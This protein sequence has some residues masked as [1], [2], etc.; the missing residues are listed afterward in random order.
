MNSDDIAEVRRL[1]DEGDPV[2]M[3]SLGSLLED[4]AKLD[5]AQAWWHKAADLGNSVA[6][7]NLGAFF[8]RKDDLERAQYWWCRAADAG[9]TQ[10]LTEV[11]S[12]FWRRGNL[13]EAE[14][15]FRQ[16]IDRGEAVAQYLGGLLYQKGDRFEAEAWFRRAAESGDLLSMYNLG[17]LLRENGDHESAEAWLRKAAVEGSA[18]AAGSL[19]HLLEQRGEGED[20]DVWYRK[21]AEANDAYAMAHLGRRLQER[22]QDDEAEVWLRKATAQGNLDATGRLGY[23][24]QR[25]DKRDEA[26]FWLRKAAEGGNTYAV[27]NLVR[28]LH[29]SGRTQESASWLAKVDVSGDTDAMLQL[30]FLYQH[31]G[32][33]ELAETWFWRAADAKNAN[34]AE[35]LTALRRKLTHTDQK[36]DLITFDTFGWLLTENGDGYRVWR[37]AQGV[38]REQFLDFAPDLPSLDAER[39]REVTLEMQELVASPTFSLQEDIP[40]QSHKYFRTSEFPQQTALLDVESFEV[41]PAKCVVMENRHRSHERVHYSTGMMILFAACFWVIAVDVEEEKAT[42]GERESSVARYLL[43]S[44]AAEDSP[45]TFNPYDRRWDGLVP[46]EH[47]PLTRMRLLTARLRTSIRLGAGTSQLEPFAPEDD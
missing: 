25:Q 12:A 23:L 17:T 43:E 39:I 29:E 9:D 7:H 32:D 45:G 44:G 3:L 5:E 4:Q 31:R 21:G 47:D 24:L 37:D 46:I 38:L 36:L 27:I 16:A 14:K 34:A 19:G 40:A 33:V 6:M 10:A 30:G 26:E 8:E 11:A 15:W 20:A 41:V 18:E 35:A 1:A 22:H 13:E 28:L 2:A 42:V